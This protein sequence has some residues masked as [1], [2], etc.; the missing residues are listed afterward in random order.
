MADRSKSLVAFPVWQSET[1]K[2]ANQWHS[3]ENPKI[4]P[5]SI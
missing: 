2:G 1:L 3:L 4:R 5:W